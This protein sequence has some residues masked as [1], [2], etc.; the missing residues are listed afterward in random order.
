MM[1]QRYGHQKCFMPTA[2]QGGVLKISTYML[3]KDFA[4]CVADLELMCIELP[5]TCKV[6]FHITI[7]W[8]SANRS[9]SAIDTEEALSTKL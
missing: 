2:H 8:Q 1:Q 3:G 4:Y 7:N 6:L 9:L 5:W